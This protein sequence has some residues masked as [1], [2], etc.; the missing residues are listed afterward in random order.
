VQPESRRKS[1]RGLS[2]CTTAPPRQTRASGL[3]PCQPLIELISQP[4][5]PPTCPAHLLFLFSSRGGTRRWGLGAAGLPRAAAHG[6]SLHSPPLCGR[7]QTRGK[8]SWE[9]AAAARGEVEARRTGGGRRG[10]AG[11][12]ERRRRPQIFSTVV[13]SR[14]PQLVETQATQKRRFAG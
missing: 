6:R 11:W 5:L 12:E 3:V 2:I 10:G 9:A 1:S 4:P 14:L 8:E 13:R 7:G